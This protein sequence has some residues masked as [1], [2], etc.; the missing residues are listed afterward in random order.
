M[1]FFELPFRKKGGLDKP[2]VDPDVARQEADGAI[3]KAKAVQP[4]ERKG[5]QSADARPVV[6]IPS[7]ERYGKLG[8]VEAPR[9]K[10]GYAV[11]PVSTGGKEDGFFIDPSALE[12]SLKPGNARIAIESLP[13]GPYEHHLDDPNKIK[14]REKLVKRPELKLPEV[15]RDQLRGLEG[16]AMQSI[17][18]DEEMRMRAAESRQTLMKGGHPVNEALRTP[19]GLQVDPVAQAR[20]AAEIRASRDPAGLDRYRGKPDYATGNPAE[21]GKIRPDTRSDEQW[22][23]ARRR[24]QSEDIAGANAW[25]VARQSAQRAD[26]AAANARFSSK[27][28]AGRAPV[29]RIEQNIQA[30][31]LAGQKE[32]IREAAWQKILELRAKVESEQDAGT[33]ELYQ[34]VLASAE[35]IYRKEHGAFP[36]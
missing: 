32:Q 9:P 18:P 20:L 17:S 8:Q 10:T 24:A 23:A 12:E 7:P 31:Q 25:E 11:T 26:M 36:G 1:G 5:V 27:D 6:P 19:G 34:D 22:E 29:S 15:S 4:G 16:V 2:V 28:S 3:A 33:R 21:K 13:R 35:E 14:H 30:A